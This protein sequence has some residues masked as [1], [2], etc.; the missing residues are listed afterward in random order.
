M[1]GKQWS[2]FKLFGFE[3]KVDVSWL[4]LALLVTW[5]LAE[6]L[7]PAYYPELPLRVYWSMGFAGMIGLVFSV[8]FH[9]T[10]HSLVARR[11]G[12]PISGITLFVFGGVA[13]LSEE[14]KT[15]RTEFLM[16]VAGPIASAVLALGFYVMAQLLLA[17][18]APEP[19]RGVAYYLAAVNALLAGFNLIPAFP[20]DGGRMLRAALWHWKGD[21]K[22][23]TR[24]AARNGEAFGLAMILLGVFN[25]VMGN[26]IGGMWW[27]L[28]GVFLRQAA[29]ASFVQL[30]TRQVFEGEPLSRFMTADPVSVPGSVPLSAF[31]ED[32]VYAYHYDL[33]PVT[34]DGRLAGCVSIHDVKKVPQEA[35]E[36]TALSAIL[37][38]CTEENSISVKSDALHA[39]A[40]MRRTGNSRLMVVDEGRL[41]GV[42]A[43]KDML[44]LIALRIDL[45]GMG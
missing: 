12:L 25:V 21:L 30:W 4:L 36:R 19:L 8:I 45:E 3:V 43:L 39:L 35:W 1:L 2:L 17:L 15:A 29:R 18:D 32:Y 26:F 6:G 27:F 11:H 13:E 42:I 40:Q 5:S 22:A 37:Q 9:E 20:L 41:V 28:I 38:P 31:V 44:E 10:S 23:A 7:F 34:E 33:F 24:T 16:A 14:P